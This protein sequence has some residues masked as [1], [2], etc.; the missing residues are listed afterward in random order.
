MGRGTYHLRKGSIAAVEIRGS[1]TSPPAGCSPTKQP[2]VL[3]ADSPGKYIINYATRVQQHFTSRNCF[4]GLVRLG[5]A[6]FVVIYS[7]GRSHVGTASIQLCNPKTLQPCSAQTWRAE[8]LGRLGS[9]PAGDGS[10]RSV[11]LEVAASTPGV[12]GPEGGPVVQN[13]S[14]ELGVT[15][16]LRMLGRQGWGKVTLFRGPEPSSYFMEDAHVMPI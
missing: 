5:G 7:G 14:A 4:K 8:A 13:S 3:P 1:L 11:L 9:A 15:L 2:T 6:L 12:A 10:S 16:G